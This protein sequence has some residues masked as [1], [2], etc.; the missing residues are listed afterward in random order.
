MV[1]YAN[2]RLFFVVE[3]AV[4]ETDVGT[5]YCDKCFT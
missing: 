1:F 4:L 3:Y 5:L 2:K